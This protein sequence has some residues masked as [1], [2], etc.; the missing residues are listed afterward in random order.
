MSTS[1]SSSPPRHLSRVEALAQLAQ[2]GRKQGRIADLREIAS[3]A[4]RAVGARTFALSAW[5][6]GDVNSATSGS[7]QHQL[8]RWT[9]RTLVELRGEGRELRTRIEQRTPT[10]SRVIPISMDGRLVAVL[11]ARGFRARDSEERQGIMLGAVADLLAIALM[12]SVGTEKSRVCSATVTALGVGLASTGTALD[13]ATVFRA[14][15]RAFRE[16]LAVSRIGIVIRDGEDSAFRRVASF[17]EQGTRVECRSGGISRLER[18]AM[19]TGRVVY[20]A[21]VARE[22]DHT[23]RGLSQCGVSSVVAAPLTAAGRPYGA[24][25]VAQP[26]EDS[27][28]AFSLEV[29]EAIAAQLSPLLAGFAAE[30]L[31]EGVDD[32]RERLMRSEQLASV[33]QLA[34]G[35]AHEVNNPLSV[36]LANLQALSLRAAKADGRLD[37]AEVAEMTGESIDAVQRIAGAVEDLRAFARMDRGQV[38]DLDI[39]DVVRDAVRIA[40]NE[41]RHRARLDLVLGAVPPIRGDRTKL[42]Q[43][44]MNL[45]VNAAQSFDERPSD[46]NRVIVT[47]SEEEGHVR[48]C[49]EDNGVGMDDVTRIFEPFFTTKREAGTGL[50]LS[51]AADIALRHNGRVDVQSK[52]GLGSS[53]V[54]TLPVESGLTLKHTSVPPSTLRTHFRARLLIVDDEPAILRAFERLLRDRHEVVVASGGEAALRILHQDDQFD[55]ILCDVMMPDVDGVAFYEE[56]SKL[57]PALQRR[58]IFCTGGEFTARAKSFLSRIKNPVLSK[59]VDA[60]VL[61]DAIARMLVDK[62][63]LVSDAI[64]NDV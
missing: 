38:T 22:E 55:V 19:E 12:P 63:A 6:A 50:G 27:Y 60:Q 56:M 8:A 13:A 17:D 33:G 25:M 5:I 31:D 41:V 23:V 52:R 29:I 62:I 2:L 10:G 24:L 4:R 7:D 54:L 18:E 57:A 47:T 58:I 44:V 16:V 11:A 32:L 42:T 15:A 64:G 21:N 49:V 40:K 9:A 39:N 59:P 36:I 20:S 46:A 14:V 30:D 61:L 1:R 35:V 51:V 45:V 3:L 37:P 26:A 53:F 43:V 48:V 34:A 28:D